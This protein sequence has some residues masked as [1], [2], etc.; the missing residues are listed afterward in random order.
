MRARF[1][2]RRWADTVYRTNNMVY[3]TAVVFPADMGY[4][5]LRTSTS[6]AA[7]AE[8]SVGPQ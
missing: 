8:R 6:F 3:A 4:L 2:L 1:H 7:F 5:T